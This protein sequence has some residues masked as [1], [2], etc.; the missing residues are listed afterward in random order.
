MVM[1]L[2]RR[3]FGRPLAVRPKDCRL[4]EAEA[5]DIARDAIGGSMPIAV[6][7][8]ITTPEGIEWH[9]GTATIGSG[10]RV[11]IDDATGAVLDRTKWGVR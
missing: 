5:L 3:L 1:T 8:V 4:S 10:M 11:R 9:I 6:T 2:L 7:T